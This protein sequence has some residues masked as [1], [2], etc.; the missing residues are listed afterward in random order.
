[1]RVRG[2]RDRDRHDG[3]NHRGGETET[4]DELA[5]G[6][7]RARPDAFARVV[8]QSTTVQLLEAIPDE[9]LVHRQSGFLGERSREI[10]E[11]PPAIRQSKHGGRGAI[12]AMGFLAGEIVDDE[13]VRDWFGY[14]IPGTG[15]RIRSGYGGLLEQHCGNSAGRI[16]RRPRHRPENGAR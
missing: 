15:P 5:S 6:R 8:E 4:L 12:E 10:A 16:A 1:L 2:P 11:G 3:R 9:R 7:E 13:L 14:Q